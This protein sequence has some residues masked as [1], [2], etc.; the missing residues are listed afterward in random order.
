MHY[1]PLID[2]ARI[3]DGMANRD[4]ANRL[5]LDPN[6]ER[7]AQCPPGERSMMM[8]WPSLNPDNFQ[9][10]GT[11]IPAG[12]MATR[13]QQEQHS[14]SQDS[15]DHREG[16]TQ[17]PGKPHGRQ[18]AKGR[19]KPNAGKGKSRGSAYDPDK[20]P[21][22]EVEENSDPGGAPSG[23]RQTEAAQ[24]SEYDPEGGV[25]TGH[26]P[27]DI[28][29]GESPMLSNDQITRQA[30]RPEFCFIEGDSSSP[31]FQEV[32]C[33]EDGPLSSIMQEGADRFDNHQPMETDTGEDAI[34]TT[35][36]VPMVEPSTPWFS[37]SPPPP[38]SGPAG[39]PGGLPPLGGLLCAWSIAT[40]KGE[41]YRSKRAMRIPPS[42]WWEQYDTKAEVHSFWQAFAKKVDLALSSS[43]SSQD[44]PDLVWKC[45]VIHSRRD[46]SYR[47]GPIHTLPFGL[48]GDRQQPLQRGIQTFLKYQ[49]EYHTTT[50]APHRPRQQIELRRKRGPQ[51]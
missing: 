39:M 34:P 14:M 41:V 26:Q 31:D 22:D 32:V 40:K 48:I 10:M 49:K 2:S 27:E 11:C 47:P 9:R 36:V 51:N 23:S 13:Q 15:Q 6:V 24:N 1:L 38:G 37:T 16:P 20:K 46:H 3:A 7:H 45:Q 12:P 21:R 25:R 19:S 4:R 44:L 42:P 35:T 17:T 28:R 5:L 50:P 18:E 43:S 30:L 33:I 29:H 8:T